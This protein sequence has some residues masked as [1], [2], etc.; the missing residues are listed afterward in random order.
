[1]RFIPRKQ[2][3]TTQP[4]GVYVQ[5]DELI[6]LQFKATGFSYLPRQPVHSILAGRHASRLRGRGL[7][8]E[9]IRD[10]LPGDDIRHM[11]WKVTARTGKPHVRVYTE[12]RDRPVLYL[13]DQ[14][15]SMF[16]G[17]R[18]AMKSVVAAQAA[19]LGAWR[20]LSLGD[21]AGAIVFDDQDM[22]VIK[23]HRSEQTVMRMLEEIVRR[24]QALSADAREPSNPGML[25]RVMERTARLAS[26][27]WL[28]CT[29]SDLTG[30][31]TTTVKHA[32]QISAHN[33]MLPLFVYDPLEA[34]FPQAGRVVVAQDEKQLEIDSLDKKFRERYAQD[35]RDRAKR[36][37]EISKS[38][39]IPVMPLCTD[40][41]V[42]EQIREQLG[43]ARG[44]H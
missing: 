10:Y 19:A 28:V 17:T 13:V 15:R 20:S 2:R 31:D 6:R 25:N 38:R 42:A 37:Q 44:A 36:L 1:M 3:A 23:P 12:E 41:D 5:L 9:E 4:N 30:V 40:Q 43:H 34:D 29:V 33:D 39:S 16:F 11:D 14:R 18:R 26:H 32:T 7:D 27:D 22:A 35:F 8:F 24:N 21:R